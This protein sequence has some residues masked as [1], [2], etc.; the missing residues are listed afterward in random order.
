MRDVMRVKHYSFRTEQAYC[1]W[2]KRFIRFH[3]LK[4]PR[5]MS[6]AEVAEFLTDLARRGRVAASA[7]NQAPSALLFL[8][9]QVLKQ[10]IGWLKQV[11]RVKRPARLP[12]VLKALLPFKAHLALTP[13]VVISA[14]RGRRA[15]KRKTTS[16]SPTR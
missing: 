4:Q 13:I 6:T 5:E 14:R 2:V 15:G 10:E 8:Y 7:Q 1:D 9:G 11:E 3:N 16:S 12:M